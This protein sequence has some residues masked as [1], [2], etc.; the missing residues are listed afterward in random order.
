[1]ISREKY[2]NS[3]YYCDFLSNYNIYNEIGVFFTEKD[4][5]IGGMALLRSREERPYT[6]KD[7]M[8]LEFLSKHI[9]TYLNKNKEL[10]QKDL[11]NNILMNFTKDSRDGLIVIDE[12]SNPIFVNEASYEILDEIFGENKNIKFLLGYLDCNYPNW[13][14]GLSVEL[15]SRDMSR[16]QLRTRSLPGRESYNGKGV[17]ELRIFEIA[18]KNKAGNKLIGVT[19]REREVLN[20]L[21]KGFSNEE[22]SAEL[23]ISIYTTKKHIR[24][25][26]FKLGAKSRT[27]LIW[28]AFNR[29]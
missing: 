16:F 20:L 17:V 27:E 18:D 24:N 7:A 4:K 23:I 22:I 5:L 14:R 21:S 26:F 11:M 1:M 25:L 19:R 8:I 6:R 2:E 13:K 28:K 3:G 10:I 9:L 15:V 29:I 12:K